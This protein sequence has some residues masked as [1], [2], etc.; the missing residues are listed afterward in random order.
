MAD[1]CYWSSELKEWGRD[2]RRSERDKDAGRDK[3]R[4]GR[5]G[6][7]DEDEKLINSR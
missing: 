2:M 5:R 3:V 6:V 1:T 7:R 4:K